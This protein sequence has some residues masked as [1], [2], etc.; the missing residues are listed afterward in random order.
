MGDGTEGQVR[1]VAAR[2]D[3]CRSGYKIASHKGL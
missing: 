1:W 3:S 2:G